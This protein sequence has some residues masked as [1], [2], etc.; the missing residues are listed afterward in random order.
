MYQ[1]LIVVLLNP[2][3]SSFLMINYIMILKSNNCNN[4]KNTS[5]PILFLKLNK[6][7][8]ANTPFPVP[9]PKSNNTSSF[10]SL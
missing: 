7:L 4:L 9:D 8:A 10:V 3:V 6:R 2:I 1:I 5:I